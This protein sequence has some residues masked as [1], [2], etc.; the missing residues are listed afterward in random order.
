MFLPYRCREVLFII[1]AV[2]GQLFYQRLYVAVVSSTPE[3]S[4]VPMERQEFENNRLEVTEFLAPACAGPPSRV[5]H[6]DL[7]DPADCLQLR[8]KLELPGAG[9][10]AHSLSTEILFG[11]VSCEEMRNPA[12]G[13]FQLCEDNS[14]SAE[15]CMKMPVVE[16]GACGASFTGFASATWR[17]VGFPG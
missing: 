6:V 15:T 4:T 10:G 1:V 17:C 3:A 16:E 14:C 2:A 5:W 13:T 11:R 12:G 8:P 7:K 9:R